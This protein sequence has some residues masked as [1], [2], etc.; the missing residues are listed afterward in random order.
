M[1]DA[2]HYGEVLQDLIDRRLPPDAEAEVRVHLQSC[3]RCRAE[4]AL[5]ER[6]RA[7]SA[8][9]RVDRD[10]PVELASSVAAALD[11]EDR[12]EIPRDAPRQPA[13]G[14]HR[15]AGWRWATAAAVTAAAVL[16]AT[17]WWT[18]PTT[19]APA[20]AA[21]DF[22]AIVSGTTPLEVATTNPPT[23]EEHFAR[24]GAPR[25]RVLDLAMMGFTLEGGR[26]H[27]FGSRR[28]ALYVYRNAAGDRI[29]CEMYEGRETDLPASDDVRESAGF[30][31]HVFREGNVTLVFWLE[32]DIICVLASR[33]P[34]D[35][36]VQLAFAKAMKPA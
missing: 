17:L 12:Q 2:G 30:R 36:V 23:L 20:L 27:T 13:A 1:S 7:M 31:F 35:Q 33:L 29:V 32:G 14:D 8:V 5:L 16:G 24:V 25:V 19:S 4:L 18:G 3:A 15:V 21:R 9:L 28:S 26:R 6:G 22:E 11:A 34:A 10:G